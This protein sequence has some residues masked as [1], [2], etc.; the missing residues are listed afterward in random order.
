M[1]NNF[2]LVILHLKL[3][4][5][6]TRG[7]AGQV[8]IQTLIL[9]ESLI[10]RTRGTAVQAADTNSDTCRTSDFPHTRYGRSSRRHKL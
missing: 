9:V 1:T 10:F 8:P 5:F 2:F 6:R 3:L 7:M 4:I